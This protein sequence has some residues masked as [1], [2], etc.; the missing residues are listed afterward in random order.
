MGTNRASR[1]IL[2]PRAPAEAAALATALAAVLATAATEAGTTAAAA[3]ATAA[4]PAAG[5]PSAEGRL[6]LDEGSLWRGWIAWMPAV[7]RDKDGKTVPA[8]VWN[9]LGISSTPPPESWVKPDFDDSAWFYWREPRSRRTIKDGDSEMPVYD[10][11]QYGI[12]RSIYIGQRC[13]RGKFE[14]KDP[15]K[16]GGLSLSVGFRGGAVAYLNGAEV[17]RSHLP[18]EGELSPDVPADDYPE[19]AECKDV[20]YDPKK[21][22]V[23]RRLN[24]RVRTMRVQI[25]PSALRRGLNVLA[26]EI[27]RSPMRKEAWN[28]CGLVS[29]ELRASGAEGAVIPATGRPKGLQVWNANALT[30]VTPFGGQAAVRTWAGGG[31]LAQRFPLSWGDRHAPLLPIRMVGAGNGAFC[32]QV[33]VSGDAPIRGLA[34]SCGDLAHA[35]GA[36]KIPS[37]SVEILYQGYP[38]AFPTSMDRDVNASLVDVLYEKPPPEVPARPGWT[39]KEDAPKQ[40]FS[41]R[42]S[43]TDPGAVVPIWLKVRV[44]RNAPA[45]EYSGALTIRA[46]GAAAVSVPVRLQVADWTL[47]DPKD[48][49][50]HVGAMH[51]PETLALWYKVQPW[52]E[53]HFKLIEKTL[54][55]AG[56]IGGKLVCLPLVAGATWIHNDRSM[57]AWVKQEDGSFKYDFSLFDRY[58]DLVLKYLK[59]EAV[60]LYVTDGDGRSFIKGVSAPDGSVIPLPPY[61]PKPESV[62]FWK[63]ALAAVRE[64]LAARGL[65]EAAVLG[66]TWEGNV[67]E[68]G[69]AAVELFKQAAPDMKLA[70]IAHYGGAG[71]ANHGMPYGYVMSVWGNLRV[72]EKSKAFGARDV[73]M[74]VAWHPRADAIWDIRFFGP[75]GA[76]RTIME[77]SCQGTIGLGPVGLDF[78]NL[79]GRGALEGAGAWNLSMCNQ[80]TGALLAPG[81]EGPLS[82]VRFEQLRE[83]LQECEARQIIEKAMADPAL[84][85]KLGDALVKKCEETLK[86]RAAAL[87]FASRGEWGLEG[88]GWQWFSTSGWE[89]R[90]LKLFAC[91]GE[92]AKVLGAK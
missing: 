33:V 67:G 36:A 15:A 24:A 46:E 21:P 81:P 70:Q 62:A 84:K 83:G 47:P 39:G 10:M 30:A 35:G 45:G 68:K 71:G 43:W 57:V 29:V 23:I 40:E 85:A 61:E 72:P 4:T 80:T 51:S 22:E 28:A 5:N 92:V 69:K 42:G 26:L 2:T 77:R 17:G 82:T 53:E 74:K 59:P 88:E 66:L 49:V 16:V 19:D 75:R 6:I 34:A 1:Q 54:R 25:P 3:E 65:G 37:S 48:F 44:P 12:Q 87:D 64:R 11:G 18:P 89:D 90:T 55:R 52:S 50:T 63:P 79:P 20:K 86:E 9:P 78:W 38:D 31:A 32:G 76:F 58:M 14:V 56:E 27:H 73:S 13:F 7:C 41:I 60:I 91:A 8:R